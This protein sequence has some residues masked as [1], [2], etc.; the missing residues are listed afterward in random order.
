M[1]AIETG[2]LLGVAMDV[3]ANEPLPPDSPLRRSD[4]ILL[5][6]HVAGGSSE[7]RARM[8]ATVAANLDHALRGEPLESVVNGVAPIV[9]WRK[10]S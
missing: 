9:R 7:S 6:P 4:R 2:A 5:S 1:G 3:Y 10:G 8:M